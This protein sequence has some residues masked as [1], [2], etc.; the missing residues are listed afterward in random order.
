MKRIGTQEP[1]DEGERGRL[2]TELNFWRDR[3]EEYFERRDRL[4]RSFYCIWEGQHPSGLVLDTDEERAW[5][6]NGASD[7]R[8]RLADAAYQK[9][10][11]LLCA[12]L[13]AV[14]VEVTATGADGE[15]RSAAILTL[16]RW[17]L[18]SLGSDGWGQVRAMMH[19]FLVDSPAVAALAVDWRKT[20]S[21]RPCET[22]AETVVGEFAAAMAA[23][24]A[25]SEMDATNAAW[26][27]I[28]SVGGEGDDALGADDAAGALEAFLV[29]SKGVRERDA[30]KVVR[31]LGEG[32]GRVEFLARGET[33]EGVRLTALRYGDD[34][35][36]P[37][38]C[39]SFDYASPWFRSEW[40]TKE[41]LLERVESDGWDAAWV[42]ETLQHPGAD[43]YNSRAV[44][45]RSSE[46][47]RDLYNVC[48]CYTAETNDAGETVRRVCV[49]SHADGSAFGRRALSTRRG[50]WNA[51]LFRR[52]VVSTRL[53]AG[54]GLAEICSADQGLVKTLSDRSNDNAIIGSLPPAVTKGTQARNA[55]IQ[56]FGRIPIGTADDVRFMT[57]PQFPA[58]AKDRAKEIR[59][60]LLDYLGIS[61]GE[62]DVTGRAKAFVAGFLRQVR[63]LFVLMVETAQ[64]CASD[65]LLAGVTDDGDVK[66]LKREDITGRFG[67]KLTLDPDNLDGERLMKKLTTF[68]QVIGMDRRGEIDTAPVMRHALFSLFPEVSR[69]LLKSSDRMTADDLSDEQSNFVKI[70]AGVMPQMNTDGGWN[71][72][73][74]LD[75]WKR[76]QEENPD[77]IGEMSPRSQEMMARWIEALRQQDTQ[78]GQNAE[79]GRTGVQG[80][81]AMPEEAQNV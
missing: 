43:F 4:E 75:W 78:Y 50:K 25:M 45:A 55:V 54:R 48:W 9:L 24:G 29:A 21:L 18:D 74:R 38:E 72:A 64:D 44:D 39:R 28:Q 77:A 68:S 2:V 27:A 22:D 7:Q 61:N 76:L 57:P 10:E 32:D 62:T 23:T 73:A 19:Y 40:L 1:L 34:F 15:R 3:A 63:D 17:M 70:K 6:F 31:A 66:G 53:L 80:V 14:S 69:R 52:E 8:V 71:Y 11:A 37:V 13:S 26:E 56:P 47:Y 33:T 58:T 41:Q 59:D 35:C 51:V 46:D 20:C 30:K 42:E 65:E 49:L 67:L 36:L 79:I 5:P 60:A 16:L 81:G 12:S